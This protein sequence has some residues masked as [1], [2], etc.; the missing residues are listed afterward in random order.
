MDQKTLNRLIERHQHWLKEDGKGWQ[1]MQ[2]DLSGADLFGADLSGANLAGANLI[3]ADLRQ[4]NLAGANLIE[5]DLRQA[6]LAGA[7]LI[8]EDLRQANFSGANLAGAKL[9]EADLRQANLYRADLTGANLYG[10]DLTGANLSGADLRQADLAGATLSGANLS[11][12]TLSPKDEFRKGIILDKPIKGYKTTAEGVVITLEI[13]KGAVVF[14]INGSKC[15][16]NTAKVIDIGKCKVLHLDMGKCKVLHSRHDPEF[17][18][19][20][21]KILKVKDFDLAYNVECSTGIHFFRTKKE[22]ENY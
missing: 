2:L 12:T 1:K 10:A 14:C 7:N 4:A 21:G 15:R 5:A 17:T 18:Y 8:C 9:I 16:T 22:A 6:N 3:E 13:P 11:G 19:T 20:P